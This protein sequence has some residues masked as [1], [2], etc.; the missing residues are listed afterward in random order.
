[1]D[2]LVGGGRLLVRLIVNVTGGPAK[3]QAAT[4]SETAFDTMR[5]DIC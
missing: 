3:L 1:M 4:I 5:A 2:E